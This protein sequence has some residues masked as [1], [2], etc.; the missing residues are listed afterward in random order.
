VFA[1]LESSKQFLKDVF[2]Y[3][4]EIPQ[5]LFGE[6]HRLEFR[7]VGMKLIV[8]H[9]LFLGVRPHRSELEMKRKQLRRY[10]AYRA[11]E[12]SDDFA[13]RRTNAIRGPLSQSPRGRHQQG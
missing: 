6:S 12:G 10:R 11:D 1:V 13:L 5:P 8:S 2:H 3:G 4:R 7:E 9:H